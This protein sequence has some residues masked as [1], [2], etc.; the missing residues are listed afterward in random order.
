MPPST[1]RFN[2]ASRLITMILKSMPEPISCLELYWP[3]D[4]IVKEHRQVG[5]AAAWPRVREPSGVDPA[6]SPGFLEV[7]GLFSVEVESFTKS[8]V[9]RQNRAILLS[10][11]DG[12]R[13][14]SESRHRA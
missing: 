13:H 9:T 5:N 2:V 10:T 6:V 1:I 12:S 4:C 11:V 7:R 3:D 14:G 8:I